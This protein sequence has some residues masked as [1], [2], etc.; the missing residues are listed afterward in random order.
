MTGDAFVQCHPKHEGP[1]VENTC[2]PS[3]CGANSQCQAVN[4]QAVCSCLPNNIGMPPNCRPECIGSSECPLNKAC[5]NKKCVDPCPGACGYNARCESI[6]HSPICSC[7]QGLTGDPFKGCIEVVKPPIMPQTIDP[8]QPSP[9]G[10]N[11]K[12]V[13]RNNE[14]ICSCLPDNIGSPPNCRPECTVNYDCATN[15]VCDKLKCRNPC[16]GICGK[17]AICKVNAHTVSCLCPENTNGDP[18][19]NCEPQEFREPP[20]QP[21]NPSPCGFNAKCIERNGA[22]SC[23]CLP[24]HYGNPYEGCKPECTLNS[25]CALNLACINNKC[26]D[27][28]PGVCGINADCTSINHIPTCSCKPGYEGDAFKSCAV[29][30]F[31]AITDR[32]GNPCVPSPCG[33]NAECR[34][35]NNQAVCACET[36]YFGTPPNCRP[37]CVINSE[38]SSA[39]ACHRNKCR[40]PCP[41]ACGTNTECNVINHSPICKCIKGYIGKN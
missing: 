29:R 39:Q 12:C 10:P 2:T 3:P 41:G 14:A 19:Y 35:S 9:C 33:Q 31:P 30:D 15:Q 4:G 13:S 37:E 22:G 5:I 8:C 36:N 38:C 18:Y 16:P 20:L 11:S 23:V 24:E 21:C 7:S 26:K 6:N 32:T 34:V 28:C 25:D 40:D 1:K 27:P 17:N